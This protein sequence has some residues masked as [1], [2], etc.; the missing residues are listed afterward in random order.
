MLLHGAYATSASWNSVIDL[1]NQEGHNVLAVDLP[2][3]SLADDVA[4][5]RQALATAAFAGPT[6]VAGH[7]YAGA[8]MTEAADKAS[9]VV[10]LVYATAFAPLKGESIV[11]LGSRFPA[12]PGNSFVF[13]SYRNGF[14]WLDPAHYPQIFCP[15]VSLTMAREMAVTQKPIV[16]DCF[17]QKAGGAAWQQIPSWCLISKN[18]MAINPDVERF[19]AKRMKAPTIEV[20]SSHAS[21]VSHPR[22]VAALIKAAIKSHKKA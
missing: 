13:P 12:P 9:N 18:D 19:M 17:A 8:V 22:E 1:L 6:I 2:L 21:P 3:T 20:N 4:V 7:S 10:G 5:A 11:D 15:D 14:V 16:P